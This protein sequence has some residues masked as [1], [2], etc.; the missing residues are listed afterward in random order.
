MFPKDI[1][2]LVPTYFP[3]AGQLPRQAKKQ[4]PAAKP[5][6][7]PSVATHQLDNLLL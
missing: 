5:G 2:K 4:F 1:E 3:A 6:H 7:L